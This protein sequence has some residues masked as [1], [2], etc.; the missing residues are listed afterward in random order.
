MSTVFVSYK[1]DDEVRVARIVRALE[2]LGFT[3]WW[4][5]DL[6]AAEPWR[7]QLSA[8][9]D[10]ASCVIVIWSRAS[11]GPSGDFVRDEAA[12]AKRR[13]I[14]VPVLIDRVEP[15]LGFGEIQAI[16]LTHWRGSA[17]DPFF[18]DLSEAVRA[19]L[20]HR[21]IPPAKGPA[22]ALIHRL[23]Y[24]ALVSALLSAATVFG[25]N[26]FS[27]QQRVCGAAWLQPSLSDLCGTLGLGERPTR[28]E[29]RSWETRQPG[30]CEALRTHLARFPDGAFRERAS[31]LLDARQV[32]HAE[33]WTPGIRRLALVEPRD[34]I[35]STDE[36]TARAAALNRAQ[37]S[38]ERLCRGF[39]AT[40]LFRVSSS[41]AVPQRW[42]CGSIAGGTTCGF[43]GEAVCE[44]QERRV[45]TVE[46]CGN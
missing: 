41:K 31:V 43:E 10:A 18:E 35:A 6:P 24:G 14:L 25:L 13:H 37:A 33:V 7:D 27:V 15:P 45:E 4:D 30:S 38:A 16:D 3:V 26:V 32:T 9:L 19:T 11:V 40:T 34:D 28:V 36:D 39:A 46:T 1:R 17:R 22:R 8:A 29:R 44:L 12:R 42:T 20:A 5:R 23:T 21:P 2:H